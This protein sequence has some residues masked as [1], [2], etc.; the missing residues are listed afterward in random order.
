[1][2]PRITHG[3]KL[4]NYGYLWRGMYRKSV[5]LC[6]L[7]WYMKVL[8]N[9]YSLLLMRNDISC[10]L[11]FKGDVSNFLLLF[12][13]SKLL[14]CLCKIDPL[15]KLKVVNCDTNNHASG[16]I[17]FD[18]LWRGIHR[19]FCTISQVLGRRD[20]NYIELWMCIRGD[21]ILNN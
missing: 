4:M 6:K 14:Y 16:Q 12:L 10:K 8:L 1:M 20:P 11:N 7:L 9:V 15:S 5:M 19:I 13:V 18:Y 3:V 21:N 17:D 2:T